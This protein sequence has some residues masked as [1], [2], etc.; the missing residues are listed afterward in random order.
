MPDPLLEIRNLTVS[1]AAGGVHLPAVKEL[2]LTLH[3]NEVVGLV[4][5]SGSGKSTALLAVMNYLPG[6]AVVESGSIVHGGVD[7]LRADR[8]T[9]DRIRG[10]RIA[11][12]YQDP[13]TALNPAMTVGAQIAEVL[14]RHLGMDGERARERTHDL[15]GLVQ[16]DDPPRIA[17]AFAHQLSGGMQQRV[18]IAMALS[19]EPD[20]LLMDEPTTALDVIVQ[21]HVLELVRSLHRQIRSAIVFVSHNLAAVAQLADRIGVLYAGELMELGPAAQVLDHPSN[22]YTRGLIAAVPR[23]AARRLPRGIPGTASREPLRFAHCVFLDRCAFAADLCRTTRPAL[24]EL[25]AGHVSRCHFAAEP[26]RIGAGPSDL[27]ERAERATRAMGEDADD[28]RPLLEVSG[29]SVEYRRGAGFLGLG[30]PH[31]VRAVREVS[32]RLPRGRVLAVVGESGSGKSTLARALL[33]LEPKVHGR[34][35]FEGADVHALDAGHLRA[36]RRRAQIVFQNPTSSLHPRK[37]VADIVARPLVLH[38]VARDDR[39]RRV[40]ATLRAV[41]LTEAYLG[42]FPEQLSGGEKQRVAL[43]R[44]FVTEPL[45][46]VLDE[47]TTALDVSVQATILELLLEQKERTGCAYLLISHDLAVVRQVADEVMVMRDGEVCESGAA[48]QLFTRPA[49][50]YT[51]ELL[52]AVPDLPE[53]PHPETPYNS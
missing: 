5:E 35:V 31:V 42:R 24:V 1:F 52:A 48:E 4:G 21:A 46:V 17:A 27:A 37:R 43:A 22:P 44:A 14:T 18:M 10:R 47:P 12:I 53:R 20:V 16:L 32:F 6:N 33:R 13:T 50:P 36:Y 15:L 45:L 41:G 11:M 40:M 30:R 2:T 25:G 7:L 8:T 3:P 9:L 49:H 28:A 26:S 51:R 19:G 39:R 29:L 34:I 23:I 38:G